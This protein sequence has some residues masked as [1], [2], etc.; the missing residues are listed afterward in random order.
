[1]SAYKTYAILV[2]DDSGMD[3][4]VIFDPI[5]LTLVDGQRFSA[6]D[7][8]LPL[9]DAGVKGAIPQMVSTASGGGDF[10][11]GG[12]SLFVSPNGGKSIFAV[13]LRSRNP[14]LPAVGLGATEFIKQ[15]ATS[16]IDGGF[17][18]LTS[19]NRV[20]YGDIGLPTAIEIAAGIPAGQLVSIGFDGL[21]RLNV[22]TPSATTPFVNSRIIAIENELKSPRAPLAN[23]P[24]LSCPFQRWE[25][26]LSSEYVLDI[27]E[28]VSVSS[29]IVLKP[30]WDNGISVTF[31]NYTVIS[32]TSNSTQSH[33]SS[34]MDASAIESRKLNLILKPRNA[35][36]SGRTEIKVRPKVGN[37]A[38]NTL[39]KVS[40]VLVGCPPKRRLVFR[41]PT[42][43]VVQKSPVAAVDAHAPHGS[44]VS[45]QSQSPVSSPNPALLANCSSAPATY[46]LPAGSWVSSFQTWLRPSYE[47]TQ[48]YNCTAYGL[49]ASSYYG[50]VFSPVFELYD[51]DVFVK[52]VKA[53]VALWEEN[54]R[55][56]FDYNMTNAQ[57]G[58]NFAA[59]NWI[60]M[61]KESNDYLASWGP[62]NYSPC[63]GP[64]AY[65]MTP[66]DAN[67][68]Y[69]IFNG[70]NNLGIIW[71]GG[72]DGMYLF[73]ARVL[74]PNYS[75][76][77]LTTQFSVYVYGAP[78]PI[79]QQVGIVLGMTASICAF[80][81]ISYL[82]YLRARRKEAKEKEDKDEREREEAEKGVEKDEQFLWK[83][84]TEY[85]AEAAPKA[86]QNDQ[87]ETQKADEKDALIA[88]KDKQIHELQDSYR[89]CL[90]DMENMRTRTRKEV[91]NA[92]AYSITKFAKD[93][94][95]T[96]DVLDMAL[97]SV[98]ESERNGSNK[99]LKDL[100]SG[101]SMT[102]DNLLKTFKRFG[103]EP[104]NPVGEVFDPNLHQALFKAPIPGKEPGT[105]SECVKIGFMIGGRVLRPAQVGVVTG[106]DS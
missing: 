85:T 42:T 30:G 60:S 96:T 80:L 26:D 59:Q 11:I 62:S 105:V 2:R 47:K 76:C 45:S 64:A 6:I 22:F 15:I 93:L 8:S 82:W 57:A 41:D 68:Q 70:T 55:N 43:V 54:G 32:M 7:T 12:D 35:S 65:N 18:A 84:K 13:A 28:S 89:R 24:Q 4:I 98:P 77:T 1:M 58:C 21:N 17:A 87:S 38:C 100:F 97:K 90:A 29:S 40:T 25:T 37:L 36:I 56:T 73:T 102:R 31:S 91:E 27:D 14:A 81:G 53:D 106:G 3:K 10:L 75:Y 33:V 74:D 101:V 103:I 51:G 50:N 48:A 79:G 78:I 46:T 72:I 5:S 63:Y 95:E 94:L 69:T 67:A 20:F 19:T 92:S 66:Q 49:P 88:E 99:H 52:T 44:S 39:Q 86:E 83:D 34:T 71:K 23:N 9:L 104:Y 61:T 16:W